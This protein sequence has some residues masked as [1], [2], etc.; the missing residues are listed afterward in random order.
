M[1]GLTRATDSAGRSGL[2][3]SHSRFLHGRLRVA[4]LVA[5]CGFRSVAGAAL[6]APD[7]DNGGLVLPAGFRALVVADKLGPVRF[8]SVAPNGDLYLKKTGRGL[9]ALR[10]T[11]SDGR[12]DVIQTFGNEIGH[13]TGVAVHNQWLYCS[14]DDAVYRYRLLPG[15]LVPTNPPET[16][17]TGLPPGQREHESKAFAFDDQGNLF[18]EVG[19]PSN[20]SGDPDRARGAK[21]VD[22]AG[23]FLQHGGFWRFRDDVT[24][25]DQ[26]RDGFHFS[27]GMRHALSVAWQPVSKSLFVFMM[28]R[29]QLNTVD[30]SNYSA[31]DNAE[32]PAEEMHQLIAGANFGWPYTYWDPR[33]K[34]RMLAPEFGGDN[35]KRDDSGKYPNPLV[36]LPAHWAPMQM[37]FYTGAQFPARYRNG[38]FVASHGS[39]NRAPLP[40]AGYKLVFVPFDGRGLPVGNYE[41]FADNFAGLPEVRSPRD[42]RYRPCGVTTGPDGSL[43]VADSEKGR[44]WRII[45]SGETAVAPPFSPVTP[46]PASNAVITIP[47]PGEVS[48][49]YQSVCAS[50]HMADGSGVPNLQPALRGDAVVTGDPDRLIRVVLE[51]PARVLP[52]DR[53][54]YSNTMPPLSALTDEQVASVLTYVRQQFGGNGS[55]ILPEQVKAVRSQLP[56]HAAGQTQ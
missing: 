43:F 22:P 54:R 44:V 7:A 49:V 20:A 14:S 48:N 33:R 6:P 15:E 39:W 46:S 1:D 35:Q 12:A 21:G 55:A 50:C 40:Q 51:G 3:C 27:T 10:D 4:A 45:Y 31:E 24:N 26:L 16:I 36:A 19:C 38:A 42:A 41:V 11:N 32:S 30:P 9:Y 25:Q 53:P 17:V 29:D 2:A 37:A 5:I 28:G 23:L 52:A 34:A 56:N 47:P 13:G 8:I 18:V